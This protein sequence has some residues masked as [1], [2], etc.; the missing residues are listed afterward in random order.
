MC[1][2]LSWTCLLQL[3]FSHKSC[4]RYF[5]RG[6]LPWQGLK[7]AT[8]KQKYEKIGEKKQSTPIKELCEGFPGNIKGFH[9]KYI[10]SKHWYTEEFAIYLNYVRRLGFDETP[11]YDFLREL[12][13]KALKNLGEVEDGVY[14]WHLLH[15]GKG[16]EATSVS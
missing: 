12:F 11:D 16:W 10:Q 7:A 15:S 6:G 2:C 4:T 8:N 5:L 3:P 14:D 9:P 1:S 13:M